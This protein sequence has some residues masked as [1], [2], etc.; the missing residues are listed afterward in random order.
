MLNPVTFANACEARLSVLW[1]RYIYAHQAINVQ[2]FA[3]CLHIKLAPRELS[4]YKYFVICEP[5][6]TQPGYSCIGYTFY[7]AL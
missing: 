6:G 4:R 2:N 1:Q 7:Y 5:F 3:V